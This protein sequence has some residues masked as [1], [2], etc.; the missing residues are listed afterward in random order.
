LESYRIPGSDL[1][2][3]ADRNRKRRTGDAVFEADSSDFSSAV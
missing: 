3:L 2:W 1:V